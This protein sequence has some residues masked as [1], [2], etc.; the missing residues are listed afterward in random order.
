MNAHEWQAWQKFNKLVHKQNT[1]ERIRSIIESDL[2]GKSAQ[3]VDE[4]DFEAASR[5]LTRISKEENELRRIL[6]KDQVF[7]AIS[8]FAFDI[9]VK[10]DYS[11][12]ED[13]LPKMYGYT[14]TEND[15]FTVNQL[16]IFAKYFVFAKKNLAK[17]EVSNEYAKN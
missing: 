15:R 6:Q 10:T 16:L 1:S 12:V 8:D 14:P 11:N 9:G 13:K 17:K 7:N 4:F 3:V 5:E 2:H